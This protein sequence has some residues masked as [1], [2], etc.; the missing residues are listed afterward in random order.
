MSKPD[1]ELPLTAPV[2]GGQNGRVSF[3]MAPSAGRLGPPA[4]AGFTYPKA[5]DDLAKV[6]LMRG[7]WEENPVSDLF[8]SAPNINSIQ[9]AIKS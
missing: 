9:L 4:T 8:F 2:A 1:F 6:D 3:L 7:N 5:G